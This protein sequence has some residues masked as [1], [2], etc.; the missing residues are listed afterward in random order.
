MSGDDKLAL[1]N[2]L[3]LFMELVV[4]A[5]VISPQGVTEG[6]GPFVGLLNSNTNNLFRIFKSLE[7]VTP[8]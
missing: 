3:I 8:S 5:G 4:G 7:S 6:S 1:G 2:W